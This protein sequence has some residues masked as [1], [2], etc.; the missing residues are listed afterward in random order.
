MD[1]LKY[2]SKRFVLWRLIDDNQRSG[3]G[4]VAEGVQF[5][6]GMCVMQWLT[7]PGSIGLYKDAQELI[8]IHGHGRSTVIRWLDNG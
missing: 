4:L 8:E 5:P 1:G 6:T 3:I 2:K 7:E